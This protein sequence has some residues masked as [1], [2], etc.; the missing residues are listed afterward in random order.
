MTSNHW[1][2]FILP[3]ATFRDRMWACCGAIFGICFTALVSTLSFPAETHLPFIVAPIGA[4]AVLVFAVPASPLAQ[5]WSVIGGNTISAL[6]GVLTSCLIQ[7]PIIAA[8][9]SVSLAIAAMSL[10]R[11]LHPPGGAAALTAV[12]AT[13]M[14]AMNRWLFPLTPV[15]LNSVLLVLCGWIFHKFTHHAYPHQAAPALTVPP[16]PPKSIVAHGDFTPEDLDA[17]IK[18]FG[19]PL[20][21]QA[22]DLQRLFQLVQFRARARARAVQRPPTNDD[23]I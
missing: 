17:A 1:S 5:P 20:D 15:A 2:G 4:S 16:G 7:D 18:D 23:Q 10:T 12:L 13:H 19:E 22:G 3:G 11:C 14:T 9:I 21:I 6:M 8:G